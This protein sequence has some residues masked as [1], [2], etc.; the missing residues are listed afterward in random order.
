MSYC[1]FDLHFPDVSDV[2]CLFVCLFAICTS[3]EKCLFRSS[4]HFYFLFFFIF[5]Y[6]ILFFDKQNTLFIFSSGRKK[7]CFL[8]AHVE[9]L[10]IHL[11]KKIQFY[12]Q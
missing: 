5:F 11:L 8:K 4:A 6:F 10:L 2:E 9:V 3:L 7:K 12:K 1:S